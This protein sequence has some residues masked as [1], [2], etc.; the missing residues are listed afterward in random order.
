MKITYFPHAPE[1]L[2]AR[3][4]TLDEIKIALDTPDESFGNEMGL[5]VHKIM[6]NTSISKKY[7]LRVFYF[8]RENE[9]EIISAY[10]T[11]KIEKYWRATIK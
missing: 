9:L 5:V 7:L 6:E 1:R 3:K 4:I 10:K 11:S 8:K 2:K